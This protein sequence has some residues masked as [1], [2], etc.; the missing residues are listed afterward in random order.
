MRVVR[1]PVKKPGRKTL[2]VYELMVVVD[3]DDA[4]SS[5]SLTRRREY[6]AAGTGRCVIFVCV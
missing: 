6:R 3:K 5:A 2:G 1:A 4:L